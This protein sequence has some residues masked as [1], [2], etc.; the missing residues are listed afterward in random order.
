MMRRVVVLAAL[1]CSA[2]VVS[3]TVP[4]M[5][6]QAPAVQIVHNRT[7]S[8]YA[9]TI[10]GRTFT[11]YRY[12]AEFADK[13]VFHPVVAPNGARVNREY[14]MVAGLAG[15]TSDH[16]HHQSM[17]FAYDE[18]NGTNFWNP[19]K[20]N[21]G[22][23]IEHLGAEVQGTTLTARLAWKDKSGQVVLDETKRVTF[24][25]GADVFWMD[26]DIALSAANG[27]VTM[28]DTKEGMFAIRLNDTLKEAG[29]SGRYINAEGLE[30]AANVWGKRSAWVAIR[31]AVSDAAGARPV[32]VAIFAHEGDAGF[33]PFWHARD[34]GLFAVSPLGQHAFDPALPEH[35]TRL[36]QGDTLRVRFR[37]AV[38]DGE[39][40]KARLDQDFAALGR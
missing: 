6:A 34:Y 13:P 22:R 8:D 26:H 15:E 35:I 29:G 1:L 32:T 7:T 2:S 5:S 18:V 23:R 30:T 28:G 27:A 19:D 31:G 36:A 4:S 40:S 37:L 11:R 39:V 10:G 38:Y 16:P 25:G 21:L 33:P 3:T 20:A 24:G 9:V 17:F 12:G 14:P